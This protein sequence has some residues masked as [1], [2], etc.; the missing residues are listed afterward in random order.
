MR[1]PLL[2]TIIVLF[3]GLITDILIY[4][5]ICRLGSRPLW[6]RLY[7]VTSVVFAVFWVVIICMPKRSGSDG[8]FERLMWGIYAYFAFY[9]PKYIYAAFDM[10]AGLP[11]LW[12]HRRMRWLSGLGLGIALVVMSGMWW[13]ALVE[14]YI[15]DVVRVDVPVDNLPK[16][17]DGMTIAQFSDLHVG[18]FGND[19]VFIRNL[20]DEINELHPDL[21]VFTGD[22]VNR[23]TSELEP[24]VDILSGL[25]APYG[26]MSILGNHDYGDYVDWP[27]D[28]DKTE[29]LSRLIELNRKMGWKLLN[30]ESVAISRDGDTLVVVGVENVGDPPFKTYGNLRA[31]YPSLSDSL[32]KILLTHNP[33]HWEREI[34]GNDS[35]NVAL[36]L[37]GHTHAMQIKLF[38]WSPAA[39]RYD[40]WGGLYDDGDHRN[41]Y[42]N[43]GTGEVAVP[44]RIG[45]TPELTFLTLKSQGK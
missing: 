4:K 43:I 1:F 21:I 22:I 6:R 36:T 27:S 39:L 44:S 17:F 5:S 8:G 38:G 20:V 25:R 13:G 14:R 40:Y 29:N 7:A 28:A 3:V 42:V 24:F 9:V 19:T 12:H 41:L 2:L 23:H 15:I 33:A 35:I 10:V 30:N 11:C 34:R 32:P 37:S 45:A 16:S 26:V 18:T 31:A